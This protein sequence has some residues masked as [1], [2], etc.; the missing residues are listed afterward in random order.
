MATRN[1][2]L[3]ARF[4]L[5]L[6]ALGAAGCAKRASAPVF[7]ATAGDLAPEASRGEA[8]SLR[9]GG[10]PAVAFEVALRHSRKGS[11]V[12]VELLTGGEVLEREEYRGD[13]RAFGVIRAGDETFSPPIDLVRYPARAGESWRWAGEVAYA[14]ARRSAQAVV[15]LGRDGGDLRSDVAL[16]VANDAGRPDLKRALTFD[17]RRGGGV[18]RRAF[19]GVSARFP[20]GET[21]RP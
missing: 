4:A 17:F 1:L 6:V 3:G 13:D 11:T 7:A 21:W 5:L 10:Q 14:G 2:D 20:K 16:L 12:S 8:A 19:G 18:V 9:L 15:T